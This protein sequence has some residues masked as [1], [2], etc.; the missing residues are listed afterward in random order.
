MGQANKDQAGTAA[1][2]IVAADKAASFKSQMRRVRTPVQ[3]YC[4]EVLQGHS[5]WEV[6]YQRD[7][8][9]AVACAKLVGADLL[10]A[11]R[12]PHV[13]RMFYHSQ[14]KPYWGLDVWLS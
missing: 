5:I 3:S 8:I 11:S 2:A 12:R 10:G 4:M 7:L 14:R 1:S 6:L 9:H 13:A